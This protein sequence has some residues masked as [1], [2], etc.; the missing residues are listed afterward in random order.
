MAKEPQVTCKFCKTKIDKSTAIADGDR[1]YFCSEECRQHQINKDTYKAKSVKSDGVTN[2][3]RKLTDYILE[4]FLANGYERHQIN[5]E[6]QMAQLKNLMSEHKDWTYP[7]I[8]Y[9]LKYMYEVAKANLFSIESNGSIL[10]LVP[11]YFIEAREFAINNRDISRMVKEFDFDYTPNIIERDL[12]IDR[13]YKHKKNEIDMN[14]I[15]D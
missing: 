14:T 4:L 9:V 5:W 10:S 1:R 7:Q 3:R 12:S 13:N 11:F 8:Q 2:D 15:L 6:L